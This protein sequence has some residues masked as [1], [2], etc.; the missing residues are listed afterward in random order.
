LK[1]E[2]TY[3]PTSHST[4]EVGNRNTSAV[5]S[6]F[7]SADPI[8]GSDQSAVEDTLNSVFLWDSSFEYFCR[9]I[10]KPP[11]GSEVIFKHLRFNLTY[12]PEVE[13]V[14]N[15][16]VLY[17]Q[18]SLQHIDIPFSLDAV[19]GFIL[20]EGVNLV[21]DPPGVLK[22]Y[23]PFR[24]L[25]TKYPR[26]FLPPCTTLNG[27]NGEAT[28][29]DDMGKGHKGA[30]N[31][32]LGKY[33]IAL[34]DPFD[35][36]AI[37]CRIPDEYAMPTVTYVSRATATVSSTPSQGLIS[38]IFCP[39]PVF[40]LN[41]GPCQNFINWNGLSYGSGTTFVSSLSNVTNLSNLVTQF[42]VVSWGLRIRNL[43]PPSTATGMI[44][45]AQI[46][47]SRYFPSANAVSTQLATTGPLLSLITDNSLSYVNTYGLNSLLQFPD[48][49]EYA[50]Q[51]LMNEDVRVIG[52]VCSAHHTDFKSVTSNFGFNTTMNVV[53]EGGLDTTAGALIAAAGGPQTCDCGGR[54]LI[55]INIRGLPTSVTYPILDIEVI[56]HIEGTPPAVTTAS[57]F[58][59]GSTSLALV[60]PDTVAKC[61]S[62]LNNGPPAN[63]IPPWI[64]HHGRQFGLGV[65]DGVI[66]SRLGL[67][68][69][70][71][72]KKGGPISRRIGR[73]VTKGVIKAIRFTKNKKVRKVAKMVGR[74]ML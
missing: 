68:A 34:K 57:T 30:S 17:H 56:M 70:T 37:G 63:L 38:M 26:L 73:G 32:E 4:R 54:T 20:N 42:R 18:I 10:A 62:R 39:N 59:T 71:P 21:W 58:E 51:E 46:P 66:S 8:I 64:M 40:T 74:M 27:A 49:D 9:L 29:S 28:N 50:F 60:S 2:L 14:L 25:C 45:I 72:R 44:E 5:S 15:M 23:I 24:N 33:E 6:I 43:Q 52:K 65:Q 61:I 22:A 13:H 67:G 53:E 48:S 7:I 11:S 36:R 55:L 41:E 31:T 3:I 1:R 35:E 19:K 69:A 47:A 16:I 12:S